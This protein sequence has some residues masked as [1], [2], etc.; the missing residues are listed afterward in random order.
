MSKKRQ[1]THRRT[2]LETLVWFLAANAILTL[3]IGYQYLRYAPNVSSW[4][5]QLYLHL[6]FLSTFGMLYLG[7]GL[8]LTLIVALFPRKYVLFGIAIPV[9]LC[10]H[11][12]LV[13]DVNIYRIFRFHFNS[14]ILNF[15]TTEGAWDSVHLG[16]LTIMTF[17][18][19]LL[20]IVALEVLGL[21]AIY[22]RVTRHA[23]QARSR[24]W[25]AR[26]LKIGV[27]LLL[28]VIASDKLMYGITDLYHD[29]HIRRHKDVFPLYTPFTI[30]RFMHTVF[31]Y[32]MDQ[33]ETIIVD[34]TDSPLNYPTA[35]LE[36]QRLQTYP[37]ILWIVIDGWRYDMFNAQVTPHIWEFAQKSVVFRNH[38]SGGNASRFGIFSLFYGVYGYY[39]HQFLGA[40]QSPVLLDELRDVGYDFQVVSSTRLTYPEFRK[41]A[42]SKIPDAV[43]DQLPG[44]NAEQKDPLLADY[45]LRWLDQRTSPQPFFSF[46]FFDAPHGPYSFPEEFNQ[47]TPSSRTTNYM[48]VGKDDVP[49]LKNSYQNA[50]LF[51]DALIGKILTY[52]DAHGYLEQTIVLIS[53]DHGEE[54]YECG[55]LGHTHGFSRYQTQVPLILHV[56]GQA[57]REITSLTSHLDVAPTMLT[58]LGYT[59]PPAVY[60]QGTSLFEAGG[61]DFVVSCGWNDCAMIDPSHSIV[62][63]TQ[64]YNSYLFEV[65]DHEYRLLDEYGSILDQHNHNMLTVMQGFRQFNK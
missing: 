8:L 43:E 51:D 25:S 55:F 48:T 37:N 28:A 11:I 26:A 24:I 63:S 14:M 59:S 65:R 41:T 1:T 23:G 13:V 38:Y 47:F 34:P 35:P 49:V 33:E 56:P 7:V 45:F 30:K 58:L 32:N 39:W 3:L 62:F 19:V 53:A 27:S 44:N 20:G 15:I 57:H 18:A 64:T 21:R 46:L 6:A 40:R 16:A 50:V 60:S 4:F 5:E 36:R 29:Y 52:L 9:I 31:G 10:F 61:H 22:R 54:F 17:S 12:A 42:F 2:M